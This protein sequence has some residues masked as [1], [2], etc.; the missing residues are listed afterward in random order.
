MTQ[1]PSYFFKISVVGDRAVGKTSL[2]D[3][4]VNDKFE[5]DYIATMGVNI[6][7]KNVIMDNIPIQLMLWDI[8]GAEQWA[9]VRKMFYRGSSGVIL[10]YDVTRPATFL[11]VTHF[12][13]ALEKTIQKKIPFILLG[14]KNDLKEL[15]KIQP[16]TAKNLMEAANAVMFFESSAKTGR[17]V[18]KAFKLM[19]KACLDAVKK[20]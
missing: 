10:V 6:T 17:N 9:R 16:E 8:G 3:R 11:N 2:I 18:E 12:L 13:Q 14:N 4:F 5:G 7:L 19:G 1:N 20:K 15:K